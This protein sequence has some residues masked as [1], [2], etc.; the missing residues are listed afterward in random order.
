MVTDCRVFNLTVTGASHIKAETVCQ[1]YSASKRTEDCLLLAV[2]DGHGGED[3][4]RSDRGSRFACNAFLSCAENPDLL[5]ALSDAKTERQQNERI[6]QLK[7]SIIANWNAMVDSDIKQD[8]FCEDE[9][10]KISERA[11]QRY[12]SGQ[13]LQS[14]YGTTLIGAI[15]TEEFWLGL[16]I[17]DGKCV[18]VSESGEFSQ[19]IPT[20]DRCFLNITTSLCDADASNEFRHFYSKSL[21][22]AVFICSDGV[23]DCFAGDERLYDFYRL[24]MKSFKESDCSTA[25][26]QLEGFLPEMSSKGSRDDMSVGIFINF[27]AQN[28]G[29]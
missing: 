8:P 14:A 12:E 24:A 29:I 27:K 5:K 4:F 25:I 2:C 23:D 19:P 6:G 7:K 22:S 28:Q 3:Y 15:F 17:G 13:Q 9:L 21:P 1:D 11:R 10:D 26:S 16:Q 18:S 20:D